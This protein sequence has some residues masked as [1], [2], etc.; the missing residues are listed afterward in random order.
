GG[1]GGYSGFEIKNSVTIPKKNTT[2]LPDIATCNY[3][4][5]EIFDP[6]NRRYLYPFT[7]CTE[8]GPR[9]S[10]ID[11]LP[12]DR[13]NTTMKEFKMCEECQ[14]EYDCPFDRRFHA[15]TNACA[16]CGPHVEML[17][18]KGNS[19]CFHN[20]AVDKAVEAINKGEILAIK[21][22]GG[23]HFMTDA[24]N[25]EA[26]DRLRRLKN[27]EEKPFAVMYPSL[28]LIKS[29][30]DVSL[31][32]QKLLCS[33]ESPI[34]LL[35]RTCDNVS[36]SVAPENPYLGVMLPYS[37]L[38]HILM[39]ELGCPVVATSGNLSDEPIFIDESE[40]INQL[41][42]IADFFLIH[43]RPISRHVDDSLVRVVNEGPVVIR[44]GRGY[45][46][47][48]IKMRNHIGTYMAVGGHLKNTVSFSID[49]TVFLSQHIGD[50]ETFEALNA[51]QKVISSFKNLY[52]FSPKTVI[53]D[54]HPAY[55]STQ[56]AEKQNLP[57]VRIQHHYA[58]VLSC[59]GENKL[60]P[61]VLGVS[62]DGSG[63]GTDGTIWG[64]EFLKV[65]KHSYDRVAHFRGFLLP[66]GNKS[67]KEPRRTALG[68]LYEVFQDSLFKMENL[69]V[70]K[71]FSP[72]E[73]TV[74]KTV[75]KR[76]IN[77]PETTS[78]GRVFDAV[79]SL[80]GL[81]HFANYEGQAAM[82]LEFKVN[83]IEIE[84]K[85]DLKINTFQVN[86]NSTIIIDWEPMIR[87]IID[88]LNFKTSI[89]FISAKFHNTLVES[90]VAVANHMQEKYVVLSGG[91]FQNKYL[92]EHTVDR[93]KN[94]GFLPY[95][96]R[97]IPPNDG[98][99]SFGQIVAASYLSNDKG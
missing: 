73:C 23:F 45:A 35:R 55:L 47:L 53:C 10:I 17:D 82:A 20:E 16:K 57:L 69:S 44:S 63:Y 64:G 99:I 97:G 7:T 18:N 96:N 43:N 25:C 50:L 68:L 1:E 46:P 81:C 41:G 14:T 9:F 80:L 74:L 56:Y 4:L 51:F 42:C 34:V 98:G 24:Q 61:P 6:N 94:E 76:K 71:S 70:I 49:N 66:G 88:D 48:S 79:S 30:C 86:G 21:G 8:C 15:Q 3:C 84:D 85:Y 11:T 52:D 26:V 60:E 59:M 33:R 22:I 92:L 90:I 28:E 75:L 65:L 19:L 39:K 95:W 27:R 62:W 89:S 37:P 13:L 31:L 91:C 83:G 32:E 29:H 58:H 36:D 54:A 12:F 2:I 5:K 40:A 87:Q 67:I 72:D 77:A 93:L 38:H 78:V